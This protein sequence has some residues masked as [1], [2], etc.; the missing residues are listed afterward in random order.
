MND[1]PKEHIE[2]ISKQVDS[3]L[4]TFIANGVS[5]AH[6]TEVCWNLYVN[7]FKNYIR[8]PTYKKFCSKTQELVE[9]VEG[10]WDET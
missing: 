7:L 5:G 1:I 2:F 3:V 9:R 4:D 6:A 8:N 10:F